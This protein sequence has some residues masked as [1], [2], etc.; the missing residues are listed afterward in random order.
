MKQ[1]KNVVVMSTMYYPDMGAPS[2]VIDKYIKALNCVYNFYYITKTYKGHSEFIN[3]A[4]MQSKCKFM[5]E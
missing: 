3:D 5:G 1:K 2:A 4:N